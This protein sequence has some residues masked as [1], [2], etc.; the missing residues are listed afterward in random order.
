MSRRS[1]PQV[2]LPEWGL[3][4]RAY[5]PSP[6]RGVDDEPTWEIV[7]GRGKS[8]KFQTQTEAEEYAGRLRA[9][10]RIDVRVVPLEPRVVYD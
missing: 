7:R 1:A 8:L 9:T 5:V 4:V 3:E 10:Q 6:R 2:H